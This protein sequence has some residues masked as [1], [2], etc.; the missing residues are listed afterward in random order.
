MGQGLGMITESRPWDLLRR[1]RSFLRM[2]RHETKTLKAPRHHQ[3]RKR[4][5]PAAVRCIKRMD[6]I[7]LIRLQCGRLAKSMGWV[8]PSPLITPN[9]MSMVKRSILI[10]K[11]PAKPIKHPA[12]V[13]K[14]R[15]PRN[16][17][18][19]QSRRFVRVSKEHL[20]MK[21]PANIL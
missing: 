12:L 6:H 13:S 10:T 4:R 14:V 5:R 21:N 8:V 18:R 17:S 3:Y 19:V 9:T 11:C 2:I 20:S 16:E 1:N 7:P 15:S